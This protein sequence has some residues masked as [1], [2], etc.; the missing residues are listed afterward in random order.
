MPKESS[1]RALLG[2]ILCGKGQSKAILRVIMCRRNQ[3][4]TPNRPSLKPHQTGSLK[5]CNAL[6]GSFWSPF[7][8]HNVP[9][10]L[11]QGPLSE[12][13]CAEGV[14]LESF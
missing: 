2:A 12:P 6:K 11:I 10:G 14:I 7:R 8:S 1:S 3:L 5:N 13:Y 4:V 9:K